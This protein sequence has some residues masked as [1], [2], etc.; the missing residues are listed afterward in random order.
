M[1]IFQN[2]TLKVPYLNQK[3]I[4]KDK[5]MEILKVY[6]RNHKIFKQNMIILKIIIKKIWKQYRIKNMM[7]KVKN[8]DTFQIGG[9]N[10]L[11]AIFHNYHI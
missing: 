3:M 8:L 2:Q 11:I 5:K 6:N 7:I 1:K 4:I 9:K 10:K